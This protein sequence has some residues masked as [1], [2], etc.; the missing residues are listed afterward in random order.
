M[1]PAIL[2]TFLSL[3]A[4]VGLLV[5]LVFITVGLG[6]VDPAVE[7][8]NPLFRLL[9]LPGAVLLWPLVAWRWWTLR[10][11]AVQGG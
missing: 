11:T 6:Q 2:L 4:A 9:V 7:G 8:V 10:R 5:G 3:Y 1:P